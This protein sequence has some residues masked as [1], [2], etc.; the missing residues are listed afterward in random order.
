[1]SISGKSHVYI[2]VTGANKISTE[3]KIYCQPGITPPDIKV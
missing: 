1:M 3:P 2:T